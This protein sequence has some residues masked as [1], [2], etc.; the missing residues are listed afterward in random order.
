[1]DLCSPSSKKELSISGDDQP[2]PVSETGTPAHLRA[3]RRKTSADLAFPN[4]TNEQS[5]SGGLESQPDVPSD[6]PSPASGSGSP[7]RS[8]LARRKTSAD[9]HSPHARKEL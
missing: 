4:A 8:G 6:Q 3:A 1:M 7:A 2:S 9:L 5:F